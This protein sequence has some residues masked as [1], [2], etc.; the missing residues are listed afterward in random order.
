MPT[1]GK[2]LMPPMDTGALKVNIIVDPNLTIK[3]SREII[4][5]AN[6]LISKESELLYLSSAIGSE[7]G[8]LSIG[9]GSGIDHISI[10]AT[11]VDRYSREKNI[12]E[13]AQSLREKINKINNVYSV[14]VMD[15][16]ATAMASIRANIDVTLYSDDL[17]F[18]RSFYEHAIEKWSLMNFQGAKELFF[19]L[20]QIIDDQNQ[21]QQK[22]CLSS[23]QI[24][25]RTF[26]LMFL[27]RKKLER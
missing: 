10:T 8:V 2:E 18:I 27:E 23:L 12:W 1:V 17:Y 7:A 24:Y 9:S 25:L 14:D 11:Y 16:G 5:E 15:F 21:L 13:I 26:S 22:G 6:E 19:I 3:H 4:K 20:T